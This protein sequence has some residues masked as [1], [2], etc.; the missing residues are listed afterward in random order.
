MFIWT[1][2]AVIIC[3]S[4]FAALYEDTLIDSLRSMIRAVFWMSV[5]G[6]FFLAMFTAE[7]GMPMAQIQTSEV[8]WTLAYLYWWSLLSIFVISIAIAL[9]K[10]RSEDRP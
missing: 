5:G 10:R 6:I 8:F 7:E 2:I 9:E 3:A 1:T 4:C